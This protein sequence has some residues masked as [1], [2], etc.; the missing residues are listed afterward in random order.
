MEVAA[1]PAVEAL[2]LAQSRRYRLSRCRHPQNPIQF[3][4]AQI[5]KKDDEKRPWLVCYT[6][7]AEFHLNPYTFSVGCHCKLHGP[8]CK[9]NRMADK[10]PVGYFLAWIAVGSGPLYSTR[11]LHFN[12]RLDRHGDN[13]V[14]SYENRVAGRARAMA[15]PIYELLLSW[16]IPKTNVEPM[17][18]P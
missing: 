10:Q 8:T 7:E 1:D 17:M 3:L 15:N 9:L 13:A 5:R 12:A 18:L 4:A 6:P 16:E 14:M 11:E 2:A